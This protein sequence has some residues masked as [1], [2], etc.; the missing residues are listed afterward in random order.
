MNKPQSPMQRAIKF[1]NNLRKVDTLADKLEETRSISLK[2][3]RML[4]KRMN[5][6]ERRMERQEG[7]LEVLLDL[8]RH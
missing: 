4:S 5:L 1:M 3:D 8:N 2:N 7:K 6:I